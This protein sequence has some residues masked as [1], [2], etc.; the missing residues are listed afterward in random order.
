MAMSPNGRILATASFI[1][2]LYDTTTNS[3]KMCL[4]KS[5]LIENI[6]WS[7]DGEK[8]CSMSYEQPAKLLDAN[9]GACV[10]AFQKEGT[11]VSDLIYSMDSHSLVT[12]FG[13]HTMELWDAV[14]LTCRKVLRGHKD[15]IETV[16]FAPNN[17]ILASVSEDRTVRLWD[18]GSGAYRYV[19]KSEED[20][21]GYTWAPDALTLALALDSGK[22]R[23]WDIVTRAWRHTF[24][25]QVRSAKAIAF[26]PDGH[27][28]ALPA[29]DHSVS[30]WDTA[31]G[32]CKQTIEV[33]GDLDHLSFSDD[34]QH[35]SINQGLIDLSSGSLE[36]SQSPTG[37]AQKL[38]FEYNWIARD[39]Q[40]LIWLPPD[41]RVRSR[42][43]YNSTLALG[44]SSSR[45]TFLDLD[46]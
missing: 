33:E 15:Y 44:H 37:L 41:Y 18:A 11:Y 38:Q 3:W 39:N 29:N 34:G 24:D 26:S 46:V 35:L 4:E 1:I 42:A 9:T 25:S 23:L 5:G 7:S 32:V 17:H 19:I 22:V 30:C 12:L 8:L 20:I 27:T 43:T 31:S 2:H 6:K 16:S 10:K 36:S 13:D 45:I 28:I 40:K 21:K 14:S